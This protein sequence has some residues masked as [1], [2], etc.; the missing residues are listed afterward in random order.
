M[1]MAPKDQLLNAEEDTSTVDEAPLK[2]NQDNP[3]EQAMDRDDVSKRD[4]LLDMFPLSEEELDRC[5]KCY[6]KWTADTT[7]DTLLQE[8][9]MSNEVSGIH[10]ERMRYA[11]A[12]FLPES[13][14]LLRQAYEDAYVVGNY[15]DDDKV[16]KFLEAVCSLIGRR[17]AR[18]LLQTIYRVAGPE[19]ASPPRTSEDLAGLVYRFILGAHFLKTGRPQ[20]M[21]PAPATWIA[22]LAAKGSQDSVSEAEWIDWVNAVAP[23]VHQSLSTFAHCALFGPDHPFLPTNPALQ[24]PLTDQQC[25]LWSDTFQTIPSS[26]ALLSPQ[27]G[28]KW[29]R[30]YSSDF[31]GFSFSTFQ[32]ALLRYQGPTVLMIQTTAGDAFGFYAG[33]AWKESRHWFGKDVDSFLFGLKPSLQYYGPTG[34][35]KPQCMYLYNP[36]IQ[37]P[38]HLHG[39]CVGGVA[40]QSP[41]LH[42]TTSF[43]QCKAQSLDA[44]YDAGPLLANNELYFD[45]DSIEIWAVNVSDEDYAK[46]LAKGKVREE[47]KEGA[48][49]H[50]AKVDRRQFL[51]DFQQGMFGSTLFEHRQQIRG[52]HS[53]VA[54]ED[55]S[56]GYFIEEKPPTPSVSMRRMSKDES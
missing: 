55:E 44:A 24:L 25:S 51:E 43:E 47:W 11:E 5:L 8:S 20:H 39:L 4:S 1:T 37:R 26:I 14:R 36:A 49:V 23:Q 22:S 40:D 33:E 10:M 12:T 31:D 54:D 7:F 45:I 18:N 38:G 21:R 42:I 27:L 15:E 41:R 35:G 28:G 46:A 48:R 32:H 53:F 50:A 16:C 34:S 56:L 52:R 13:S 29:I 17:S 2:N 19:D 3:S 6:A 9:F 30:Q